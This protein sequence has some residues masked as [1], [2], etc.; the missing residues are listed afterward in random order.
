MAT[1]LI[2]ALSGRRV[3]RDVAMTGE[4]TLT[5]RVLPIGGLKEKVLA[6]HRFG[7]KTVVIPK[8]N[9]KDLADVPQEV[10]GELHF[11]LVETMEEV[12][13]VALVRPPALGD[14]KED[15]EEKP[16]GGGQGKTPTEE[17][18]SPTAH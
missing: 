18:D 6:A 11:K 17:G 8:D 1:A 12:M 10:Q 5:G 4:M 2:S 16:I 9:E 13:E 14:G 7:I 3:R 15:F